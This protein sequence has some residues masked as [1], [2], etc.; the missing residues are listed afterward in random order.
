MKGAQPKNKA[1][2]GLRA[3]C[4]LGVIFYHADFSWT[5]GGFVGVDAFFVISGFLITQMIVRELVRT[6]SLEFAR[7]YSRRIRRLL[8]AAVV[9]TLTTIGVG[10]HLI[11]PLRLKGL[12]WDAITTTLYGANYRFYFSQVDYL[13]LGA[14]PSLLLHYWSLA[15]EEQFYLF[16]P[17]LIFIGYK[18]YKRVGMYW[19][20]GAALVASFLYSYFLTRTNP[21]LAFYSIPT[22]A[23]EF[24]V[25]GIA[26][27]L[28]DKFVDMPE[29]L[30]PIFGWTGITM[31]IG[32]I[33][34]LYDREFFPGAIA[35]IPVLGTAFFLV[36]SFNG[37][38]RGSLLFS[39]PLAYG[40]GEISYSLYLWHWPV[41]QLEQEVIGK[42]PA[43]LS[44]I[45][46]YAITLAFSL[47]SYILIE[48]PVRNYKRLASRPAYG[49]VWGGIATCVTVGV[50]IGLLGLNI[51]GIRKT[52]Q[53]PTIAT[54]SGNTTLAGSATYDTAI[55]VDDLKA[56]TFDS[57]CMKSF[58]NSDTSPCIRGDSAGTKTV[59]IFGDSHAEEWV[60]AL[61]AFGRAEHVKI[62]VFAKAGCPAPELL[63]TQGPKLEPYPQCDT[64]RSKIIQEISHE[65]N[66][67][68]VLLAAVRSYNAGTNQ[69][70][71]EGYWRAGYEKTLTALGLP[72][73]KIL[74]LGDTPYPGQP[75]VVDCLTHHLSDPAKCDVAKESA[76]S[77][78]NRLPILE[79]VAYKYGVNIL[80]STGWFCFN[81]VCP[82]VIGGKVVYADNS[83]LTAGMSASLEPLV[84]KALKPLMG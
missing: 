82:A 50:A 28:I 77:L 62:E 60:P 80:D 32:S 71:T 8:P 72:P 58:A 4:V 66:I 43:G 61:D 20:M 13:N 40:I 30:D 63:V 34:F 39:N 14:K 51:H 31:L 83:H 3:V 70:V 2:Q 64:W 57:S 75:V 76:V 67:S 5:P 56:A 1:I 19:A 78:D 10:R 59:A 74:L 73:K 45:I 18:L 17:I 35:A 27:V 68:L 55:T 16:W 53:V 9:V 11:S 84:A 22:R 25:G 65:A 21:T 44:L 47:A 24:A 46:Y 69:S 41:Y 23:W 15:V 52:E 54:V 7:F 79:Q 42:R 6:E 81:S 36:G 26:F 38:F 37:G 29:W 48:R 49:F 12:G 33:V